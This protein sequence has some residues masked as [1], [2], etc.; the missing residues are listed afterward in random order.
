MIK[1]KY[2]DWNDLISNKYFNKQMGGKEVLLYINEDIINELGSEYGENINNFI[3]CIKSGPEYVAENKEICQKALECYNFWHKNWSSLGHPHYIAYLSLFVLAATEGGNFSP[4]AYYPKLRQLLGEPSE[5][6]SYPSFNKMVKLW[7]N[8]EKWSKE[9]M[10]G[11]LGHFTKR[12][13]GGNVHIGLP[14]SQTILTEDERRY[15]PQI[16]SDAEIDPTDIPSDATIKYL[17]SK[18]GQSWLERRTLMLLRG[19]QKDNIGMV[20]ALIDFVLE[21]LAEWDGSITDIVPTNVQDLDNISVPSKPRVGLRLCLD[22]D[23][24]SNRVTLTLRFKT[25]RPFPDE[26]LDFEHCGQIYSCKETIP[27]WSTKIKNLDAAT[28]NWHEG[29]KFEDEEKGWRANFKGASTRL[30]LPGN[31]EGFSGWI[32]SH[33]LE[34]DCEFMVVCD[35]RIATTVQEWGNCSCEKL[36][37]MSYQGLPD[38]W[39]LF[40]GKSA[41][42]SHQDIDVLKLS[43]LLR[44]RLEG[45]IRIGKSNTYLKFSPPTIILEGGNG[46]EHVAINEYEIKREASS[47]PSWR[48]PD[49]VPIGLPL[50]IEVYHDEKGILKRQVIQ[51]KEPELPR[52]LEEA[53]NR[54]RSGKILANVV[55][56]P[57]ARGALVEGDGLEHWD[58]IPQ[59]VPTYISRRIVFLGSRP[60]E[61]ADWPDDVI[62]D[63]WKPVWAMAKSGRKEWVV[64]FCGQATTITSCNP[65]DPIND[66]R[67]IKRWKEAIWVNRKRNKGPTLRDIKLLWRRYE[68]VAKNA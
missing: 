19:E 52:T 55:I 64:H 39:S 16:F 51:L 9:Y 27:N 11:E 43:S 29:A 28:L 22:L 24:L 3:D 36:E 14:L 12:I 61:V 58:D 68:E 2:R 20:D 33:H 46:N 34:R 63:K 66:L 44:L 30:F 47:K 26:G 48:I 1:M 60:G 54:D 5:S 56:P 45:G 21:E 67:A 4:N 35:D 6:G 15:L 18:Y 38:G 17:L 13:R 25:N 42:K 32:E 31:R 57:Y 8:L 59:F 7:D 62:P 23:K 37:L 41:H 53:P 50:N 49:N 40:G 10:N 65:A